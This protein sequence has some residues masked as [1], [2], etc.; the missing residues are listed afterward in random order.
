MKS[1]YHLT[2]ERDTQAR[3]ESSGAG[4]EDKIWGQI[5][6]LQAPPVVRHFC[7]TVCNNL[8][9]TKY[10]LAIKKIAPNVDCPI[11]LKE[12]KTV[13]HCL[14]RCPAAVAVW[15]DGSR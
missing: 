13:I 9:P 2:M 5:W 12:P 10:N 7:W 14:W 15:Q 3:G 8:L 1:A 4:V 11:C 6:Q